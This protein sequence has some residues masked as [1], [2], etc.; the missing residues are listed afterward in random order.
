MWVPGLLFAKLL[1]DKPLELS[2]GIRQ[3]VQVEQSLVDHV[4]TVPLQGVLSRTRA[5]ISSR[6]VLL[7]SVPDKAF[8]GEL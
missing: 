2:L 6:F 7:P 3:P 8:K 5:A 1:H 4:R